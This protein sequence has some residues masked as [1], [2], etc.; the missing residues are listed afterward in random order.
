MEDTEY[1]YDYEVQ[2]IDFD[3]DDDFAASA[4]FET[5]EEA[6]Q[7]YDK[8]HVAGWDYGVELVEYRYIKQLSAGG[9]YTWQYVNTTVLKRKDLHTEMEE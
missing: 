6:E 8:I 3:S 5:L 4:C 7:F 1:K 9:I 2:I